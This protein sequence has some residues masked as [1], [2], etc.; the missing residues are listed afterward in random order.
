MAA[1]LRFSV[2]VALVVILSIIAAIYNSDDILL[3]PSSK[4]TNFP[5][6][7]QTALAGIGRCGMDEAIDCGDP[8]VFQLLMSAAFERFKDVDFYRFGKPVEGDNCSCCHMAW[9]FRRREGGFDEDNRNFRVLRFGDG[10]LGMV[11]I[12]DFHSGGN[13]EKGMVERAEIGVIVDGDR[14][15]EEPFSRGKYLMYAGGGDRCHDMGYYSWKFV[16][17]LGEA[18]FLNRTLVVDMNVCLSKIYTSSGMDEERDFRFYYDFEMLKVMS[19]VVD[20]AVFW[21]DWNEWSER[22][23]LKVRVVE[24][25]K[26]TPGKLAEWNESLIVRRFGEAD[27]FWWRVC[28][29]E[30]G[31]VIQQP[32]H[33]LMSS[34]QLWS[35]AS[36][37][38]SRMAWEY[39][40]VRVER[41]GKAKIKEAWPNLDN[42]T[43]PEAVMAALRGKGV[44]D[45]RRVYVALDEGNA[46]FFDVL[47]EKYEVQSLDDHRDLWDGDSDWYHDMRK[48]NNGSDVEFDGY[49]GERVDDGVFKMG[50]T[51]IETFNDLTEDCRY[52]VNRC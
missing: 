6:S 14:L 44:E 21:T 42:D 35:V 24:G 34:R 45:G 38:T 29:G 23:G 13:V 30:S 3:P 10:K 48:M 43:S 26:A 37:I 5:S 31:G 25:S 18:E 36:A 9:R 28:E 2:F 22:D 19:S 51:R 33:K 8:E 46:S 20:Q 52:G 40:G 7:N 27:D 32:W 41:R 49:M 15:M 1:T 47:K 4:F 39:D 17:A 12:G 16:C 11:G 50:K